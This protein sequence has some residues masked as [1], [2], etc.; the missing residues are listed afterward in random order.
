MKCISMVLCAS[1]Q[2]LVHAFV[3]G[4]QAHICAVRL[5]RD[6]LELLRLA[7]HLF[8]RCAARVRVDLGAAGAVIQTLLNDAVAVERGL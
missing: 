8:G 2:Q 1:V 5:H 7:I 3:G 4:E 6:R